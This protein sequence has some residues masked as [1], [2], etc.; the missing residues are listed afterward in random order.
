MTLSLITP[1]EMQAELTQRIKARRLALNLTQ[2]GL[3]T[4]SGVSWG[5]I[6]RFERTGQIALESL[7]KLAL[8]L[9]CLDDFEAVC[10]PYPKAEALQSLDEMLAEKPVR[11]KGRIK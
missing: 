9:E 7:L 10:P 6:K 1:Q 4:R 5:T 11:K 3:A 2:V 8:V